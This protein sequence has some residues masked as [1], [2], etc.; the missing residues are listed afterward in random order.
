MRCQYNII[1]SEKDEW[2]SKY[3]ST[4]GGIVQNTNLRYG[5]LMST[6]NW[7]PYY[8]RIWKKSEFGATEVENSSVLG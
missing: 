3:F 7:N 4:L 6:T 2:T 5:I 8:D 1:Q